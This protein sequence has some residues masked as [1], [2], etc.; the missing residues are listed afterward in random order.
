MLYSCTHMAA[1]GVKGLSYFIK[2][3]L[4]TTHTSS[5]RHSCHAWHRLSRRRQAFL[6]WWHDLAFGHGTGRHR[7][8]DVTEYLSSASR[9]GVV[10]MQVVVGIEELLEPLNE[11]KVVL[12]SAF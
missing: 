9:Y 4:N 1:A 3:Q 2:F 12:E 8:W 7:G 11:L 10:V 5:A 6:S